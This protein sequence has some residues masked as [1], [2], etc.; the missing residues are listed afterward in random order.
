MSKIFLLLFSCCCFSAVAQQ[1][2]QKKIINTAGKTYTNNGVRLN[3]SVGEPIVGNVSN[4]NRVTLSQGFF[5][6]IQ[7][8]T[9]TNPGSASNQFQVYPNPVRNS[10]VIKGNMALVNQIQ[11]FDIAGHL[12][13]LQAISSNTLSMNSL[14]PG[15]YFAKLLGKSNEVL[16]TFKI[17]KY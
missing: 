3:V 4:S 12:V 5:T 6:G 17:V 9:V 11:L 8:P 2:I 15:Y 7:K 1:R 14:A 13:L 10:L 16:N